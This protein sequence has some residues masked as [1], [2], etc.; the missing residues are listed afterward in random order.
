MGEQLESNAS[1]AFLGVSGEV[2]KCAQVCVVL[3]FGLS[4]WNPE[5]QIVT[6]LSLGSECPNA[7]FHVPTF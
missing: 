2:W 5:T 1:H 4:C 3:G 6:I 7:Q